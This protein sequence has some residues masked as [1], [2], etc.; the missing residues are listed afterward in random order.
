MDVHTLVYILVFFTGLCERNYSNHINMIKVLS[1]RTY[2]LLLLCNTNKLWDWTSH[3][4]G[5]SSLTLIFVHSSNELWCTARVT[6]Y[7]TKHCNIQG[8]VPWPIYLYI[9][10][11]NFV[12][13]V[14]N[15]EAEHCNLQGH[16]SLTPIYMY[17]HKTNFEVVWT[18][19]LIPAPSSTLTSEKSTTSAIFPQNQCYFKCYFSRLLRNCSTMW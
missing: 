3:S 5:H 1:S 19:K 4:T 12:L 11:M 8:T 18:R 9:H 15:Y 2:H 7:E 14:T 10:K 16:S 17:N 13:G 6:D